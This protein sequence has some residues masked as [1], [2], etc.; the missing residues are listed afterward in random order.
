MKDKLRFTYSR[1]YL[2]PVE[3]L[4]VIRSLPEACIKVAS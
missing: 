2:S 3:I 1:Q 4:N